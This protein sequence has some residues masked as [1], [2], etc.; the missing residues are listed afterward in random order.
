[1]MRGERYKII[2]L[3]SFAHF[4]LRPWQLIHHHILHLTI[5]HP[6]IY[7]INYRPCL[8]LFST[9]CVFWSSHQLSLYLPVS[10]V[11]AI[12]YILKSSNALRLFIVRTRFTV[13]QA[14]SLNKDANLCIIESFNDNWLQFVRSFLKAVTHVTNRYLLWF[15]KSNWYFTGSSFYESKLALSHWFT[16][17]YSVILFGKF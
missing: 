14:K 17:M 9:S 16:L 2:Q 11:Q 15:C 3:F 13:F 7:S 4:C 1:M 12:K 8:S 6:I 10:L 5:L